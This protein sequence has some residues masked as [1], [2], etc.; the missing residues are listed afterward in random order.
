MCVCRMYCTL[1]FLWLWHPPVGVWIGVLGLL[2]VIVPLIR[3]LSKIGRR[4]KA[5]WTLVMFVLL[6]LEIKSVYQDRNEHDREQSEAR[7]RETKSFETIASG[8]NNAITQSEKQFR[9]TVAQQSRD[10]DAVMAR[11]EINTSEI[12]GGNSYIIVYPL[13]ESAPSTTFPL[14]QRSKHLYLPSDR[15]GF[16]RD[17]F[18][19]LPRDG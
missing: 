7:E 5:V 12:T 11:A 17:G 9:E 13:F 18:S 4:E 2:G 8:V 16:H 6:L 14:I 3:D 15:H 1:Q 19:Y 10:F